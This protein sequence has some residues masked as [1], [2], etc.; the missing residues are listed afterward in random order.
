LQV[1]IRAFIVLLPLPEPSGFRH[2][3][4]TMRVHFILTLLLILL[5]ATVASAVTCPGE[6]QPAE[7]SPR[8]DVQGQAAGTA[9]S[10]K[11]KWKK[12]VRNVG[13]DAR[14]LLT[15]PTRIT[16]RGIIVTSAVGAGLVG[17]ILL[18][19]E[20]YDANRKKRRLESIYKIKELGGFYQ[21]HVGALVLYGS[22]RLA[23]HGP[24]VE[25]SKAMMEA[26]LFTDVFVGVGKAVFRRDG[27]DQGGVGE[28]FDSGGS[29]RFPSGHAAR[30]FTLAA[31]LSERHGKVAR[32]L[33]YPLATLV[34]LAL[35]DSDDHATS[36]VVA[37]A[38]LGAVV[39]RAVVRRR[40]ER[41]ARRVRFEPMV[42][43]QD[44]GMGMMVR[45]TIPQKAARR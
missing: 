16:R 14:Y 41:S 18:D 22:G 17:A 27:P 40:Q 12:S 42:L 1:G 39:G 11:P 30:A 3:V 38:A 21:T 13:S 4:R 34:G 31:V 26:L 43:Q 19:Q 35:I 7:G 25:T 45:I 28:W 15:F 8:V 5:L 33:S 36:D 32:W 20:I 10:T 9:V 6:E 44:G 2:Q 24:T 23:H 37:G 29:G